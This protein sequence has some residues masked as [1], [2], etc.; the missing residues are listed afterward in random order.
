MSKFSVPAKLLSAFFTFFVFSQ[1]GH[2]AAVSSEA[3]T[4]QP[5]NSMAIATFIGF[6]SITLIITWW[7]AKQVHSSKDFLVAG[8]GLTPWQNGMAIAGD[9]MS[10][11]TFLGITG[12]IY[13]RGQDAFVL[14]VGI[15]V[16]WPM[17]LMIIAE[18]FRNLGRFT[19]IDVVSSRLE[20]KPVRIM[21][22]CISLSIVAFY[23]IAQMVGAGT[24]I[25][26]LFGL[27]YLWAILIVGLLMVVYVAFGGMVATTWVQIIKASLLLLGG[28][29]LAYAILSSTGF[30]FDAVLERA[31]KVSALGE[32]ILERGGWFDGDP[33][34]VATVALT[35]AF[36]V[37]GLPHI[38]MRFFTVKDASDARQSVFYATSIMGYFYVLILLIGLGSVFVLAGD[39]SVFDADGKLIG[40]A[41]MVAIHLSRIVGGD[42]IYGFMAAVCFATI[43]AVVAGLTLS[44]AATIAHDLYSQVFSDGKLKE[45]EEVKVTRYATLSIG[46]AA[47]ALGLAFEGE[48]VA[49]TAALALA[50]GASV[51]CPVI[52]LSL[53]WKGLTSRGVV[54]GGY[55]GLAVC[56][57]LI[58][59]SPGVMVAA[60]GY[61][62][63]IFPYT[64]PTVIAMPLTFLAVILFSRLDTSAR[65]KQDRKSYA[66]QALESELGANIAKP[67]DH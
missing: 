55:I 65:A 14:A 10:A 8:G 57:G 22:S 9:F 31:S 1:G 3:V 52:L 67:L 24:L 7:A 56:I 25:Q 23:L 41:N 32:G 21:A 59:I 13:F 61:K 64:Y 5:L 47:V 33:V 30:S 45:G 62:E 42:I 60:L 37:M 27:D 20:E 12:A 39:P 49:V 18:R 2:A 40:G 46:L 44:G 43:L 11:A 16:G 15:M 6:V 58:L 36:G 63:A 54:V 34:A 4:K 19:F 17:I 53:Y 29:Y 50:I 48:N 28:S 38:L 35:M 26:V 66:S 51:N